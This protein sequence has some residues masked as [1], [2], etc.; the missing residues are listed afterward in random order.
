MDVAVARTVSSKL[1]EQ[2]T[3]LERRCWDNSQ[4][5]RREYFQVSGVPS[6]VSTNELEN[7]LWETF[8]NIGLSLLVAKCKCVIEVKRTIVKLTNRKDCLKTCGVKKDFKN[9]VLSIVAAKQ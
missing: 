8:S 6:T 1:V 5:S 7:L 2:V 3:N 4:Y 9:L